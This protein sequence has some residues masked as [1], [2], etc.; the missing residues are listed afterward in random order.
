[1]KKFLTKLFTGLGILSI[2][3]VTVNALSITS[4][5]TLKIGQSSVSTDSVGVSKSAE[6]YG[7][8]YSNSERG[9]NFSI[10]ACWTGWPYTCEYSTTMY[11]GQDPVNHTETQSN[12]SNF[13]VE[14]ANRNDFGYQTHAYGQITLE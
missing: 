4:S 5:C 10:Y 1:M 13:Y 12:D 3:I 6:A 9:C 8:C 7:K 11:V 14:L 2:S